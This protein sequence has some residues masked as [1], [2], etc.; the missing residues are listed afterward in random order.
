MPWRI[1]LYKHQVIG[2]DFGCGLKPVSVR[3]H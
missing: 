1:M 2:G 3:S